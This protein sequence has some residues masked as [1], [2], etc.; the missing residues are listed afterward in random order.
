MTHRILLFLAAV[1]AAAQVPGPRTLRLDYVHTGMAAEEQFAL[2]GVV[3]EGEWP[4]PLDRWTDESNLGKY[5]FQVLDRATNRVIYSRGFAS[6]YGEWETTG[7]AKQRRRAF[8]ESVRF[9]APALPVQMCGNG[10]RGGDLSRTKFRTGAVGGW[11]S[12]LVVVV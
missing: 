11:K 8:S 4:G 12:Q 3:L 1:A 6:T 5:Y 2:D 10:V 9:P 7:E